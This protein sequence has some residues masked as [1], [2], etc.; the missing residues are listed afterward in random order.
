MRAEALLDPV[1][2][3]SQPLHLAIEGPDPLGP[4]H[5]LRFEYPHV[6]AQLV[7]HLRCGRA[8]EQLADVLDQQGIELAHDSRELLAQ[9]VE[10]IALPV[11]VGALDRGQRLFHA[12]DDRGHPPEAG[13]QRPVTS[14][15]MPQRR[16]KKRTDLVGGVVA[17]ARPFQPELL[18]GSGQQ[19]DRVM[20][21][22]RSPG[23]PIG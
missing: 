19:P 5:E 9:L 8:A 14:H 12:R 6:P 4:F 22:R 20:K 21:K 23:A 2:V 7:D 18:S 10:A 11:T 15:M 1:H 3:V 13:D 16:R 17:G